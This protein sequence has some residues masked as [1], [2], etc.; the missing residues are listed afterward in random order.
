MNEKLENSSLQNTPITKSLTHL[1]E[2]EPL[3][4]D[5]K[6]RLQSLLAMDDVP[7]NNT[8]YVQTEGDATDKLSSIDEA[9]E[10][11]SCSQQETARGE[12]A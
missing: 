5:Y 10:G 8:T 3:E 6:E 4:D 7:D 1:D 11:D 12:V 2:V 9:D